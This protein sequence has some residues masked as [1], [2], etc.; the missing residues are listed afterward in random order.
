LTPPPGW[1]PRVGK[2]FRNER[3]RNSGACRRLVRRYADAAEG[4]RTGTFMVGKSTMQKAK[5]K[6]AG[7]AK[8]GADTVRDIAGEAIRAAAVAAAGVALY[9][10]ADALRGT[11]GKAEAAAPAAQPSSG[12]PRAKPVKRA[13]TRAKTKRAARSARKKSAPRRRSSR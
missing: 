4:N 3:A 5:E 12:S 6:V 8:T 10:T 1:W 13:K 11:A 7:A 9:R 2:F